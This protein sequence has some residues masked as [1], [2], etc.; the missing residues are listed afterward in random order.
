MRGRGLDAPF[1]DA[2]H[3]AHCL[4]Q[5]VLGDQHG[6]ERI[7]PEIGEFDGRA[8]VSGNRHSQ[9]AGTPNC[10]SRNDASEAS[11]SVSGCPAATGG[12]I[13]QHC[14]HARR[15]PISRRRRAH[16]LDRR[17][18]TE[19]C[20]SVHH[21]GRDIGVPA[22]HLMHALRDQQVAV[23]LERGLHFSS[24]CICST[25][26]LGIFAEHA[27]KSAGKQRV[28]RREAMADVARIRPLADGEAFPCGV[29]ERG[30]A[31]P[32]SPRPVGR[33]PRRCGS[34]AAHLLP[35]RRRAARC[36]S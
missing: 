26:P 13:R 15:E 5:K 33:R 12:R 24:S 2:C 23:S 1:P 28:E 14:Q 16:E 18:A 11:T 19:S 31:L 6:V 30:R 22:D 21:L 34:R 4:D 9:R 8:P 29:P 10:S 35:S 36:P 20:R 25:K 3:R 32:R 7:E 27:G 17:W